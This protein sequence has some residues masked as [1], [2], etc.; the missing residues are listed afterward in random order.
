MALVLLVAAVL[1]ALLVAP[2][3]AAPSAKAR[4]KAAYNTLAEAM[5]DSADRSCQR[6]ASDMRRWRRDPEGA[7][8][9]CDLFLERVEA[10]G[11]GQGDYVTRAM[12][13]SPKEVLEIALGPEKVTSMRRYLEAAAEWTL[14]QKKPTEKEIDE[15]LLKDFSQWFLDIA[16]QDKPK[17]NPLD[18]LTR[19]ARA[20]LRE[21]GI[22]VDDYVEAQENL[23]EDDEEVDL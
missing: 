22:A 13:K 3:G 6:Q 5:V 19:D 7:A 14:L 15:N 4:A 18:R 21:K 2:V 8:T 10:L 12:R 20:S 1:V 11:T 23:I 17:A 16:V 9:R